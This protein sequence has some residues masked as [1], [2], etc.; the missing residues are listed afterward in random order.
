MK[1]LKNKVALITGAAAGMGEVH[2]RRFIEEGS[3]VIIGDISD[4]G[5]ELA[6][7]LGEN[8]LFV[9]LDVTSE[10]DW[11]NAVKKAEETFGPVSVLV[12]NAGI[13]DTEDM[14]PETTLE[15]YKKVIGIN[16]IGVFLGMKAV[17]PS[18]KKAE[19]GS[20]VNISSA[21]GFMS[22]PGQVAYDASKF[23]VRGM[24][25]TAK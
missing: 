18:M 24:T 25:K 1:N 10:E 2:A 20:I 23:A 21:S 15:D 4:A 22:T 11:E 19:N 9:K 7:E 5:K 13:G 3:K 6:D 8:A 14:I 16:Q 17:Y 12:N